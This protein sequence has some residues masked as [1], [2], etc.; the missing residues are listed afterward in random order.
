MRDT[1]W[2]VVP[3]VGGV[4]SV[5]LSARGVLRGRLSDCEYE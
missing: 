3:A 5:V 1:L 2:G 4:D